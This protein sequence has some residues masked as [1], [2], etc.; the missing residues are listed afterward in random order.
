MLKLYTETI[1][2]GAGE[3]MYAYKRGVNFYRDES[4]TVPIF[5]NWEKRNLEMSKHK[6][7]FGESY[8]VHRGH[9]IYHEGYFS[10]A[11]S[12]ADNNNNITDVLN[13]YSCSLPKKYTDALFKIDKNI[14]YRLYEMNK[15]VPH[16]TRVILVW[17][18]TK[19]SVEIGDTK[20][21]DAIFNIPFFG[22]CTSSLCYIQYL[23][24]WF[25][26]ADR[27]ALSNFSKILYDAFSLPDDQIEY[28]V[29]SII[30][31]FT[32]KT[33]T[34]YNKIEQKVMW[35]EI[36]PGLFVN[37]TSTLYKKVSDNNTVYYANVN[38][39]LIE[40]NS[41]FFRKYGFNTRIWPDWAGYYI[42]EGPK[43][44]KEKLKRLSQDIFWKSFHV[45]IN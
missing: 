6:L 17:L 7:N 18:L 14:L 26:A 10:P 11:E 21:K 30:Y 32:Y 5:R 9:G 1:A 12:I 13:Y 40:L 35:K 3:F 43:I 4:L 22:T 27:N 23:K 29:I 45:S 34:E 24:E 19:I 37:P 39:S 31:G 33:E 28:E 20:L 15:Y 41:E 36:T 25:L 2:G 42:L 44:E 8:I 16:F 38:N